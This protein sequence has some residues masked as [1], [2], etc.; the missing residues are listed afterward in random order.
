MLL[1]SRGRGKYL[2]LKQNIKKVE[3]II[4]LFTFLEM[5]HGGVRQG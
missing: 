5:S 1:G 2:P 4:H 3:K